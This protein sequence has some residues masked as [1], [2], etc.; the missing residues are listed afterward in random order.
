MSKNLH[1]VPFD[2]FNIFNIKSIYDPTI[3]H[4]TVNGVLTLHKADT[5]NVSIKEYIDEIKK[6]DNTVLQ[7]QSVVNRDNKKIHDEVDALLASKK[8]IYEKYNDV[9][10]AWQLVGDGI[11][12]P[13]THNANFKQ[14]ISSFTPDI[15]G[16]KKYR[17]IKFPKLL[18][19]GGLAWLEVFTKNDPATG[20]LPDGM[21]VKATGKPK[22][23]TAEWKDADENKIK[24]KVA[25]GSTIYLHIYTEALYGQEIEILLR[26][27]KYTIANLTPT[28]SDK[29]GD[30]IQSLKAKSFK[31]FTRK[32]DC[33]QYDSSKPQ[34]I[35]PA[36]SITDQL[37]Q[38]KK[39]TYIQNV[40]KCVFAV[41]IEQ[42]W[43]FQGAGSNYDYKDT[44][45]L[46]SGNELVINPFIFHKNLDKGVTEI[47]AVLKVSR[48]DGKMY[49]G[50]LTGNKPVLVGKNE[51]KNDAPEEKQ[52][53]DF[54]VGVF[55]DGTLNNMFNSEARQK[56]EERTHKVA[57]SQIIVDQN[58]EKKYRYID[59]SSYENDPSNPA[60]LY[61]NY[62]KDVESNPKHK[63]LKV[64]TEGIGTL[65]KPDEKGQLN[66][67]DYKDDDMVGYGLG[68][69]AIYE[70]TGIKR[71]V[72]NAI[73]DMVKKMLPYIDKG[74]T[75]G[76]LTVDVFGFSRGAA[77]A[78]NFVHEI[79]YDAYNVSAGFEKRYCDQHGYAVSE[80]YWKTM[81]L[82]SNGHLGYLLDDANKTFDKLYVRFAGLYDTVP[83][84][85]V[86]QGNDIEDLGLDSINKANYVVH[87]A[88]DNEHRSNFSLVNIS[89]VKKTS[90]ESGEKG[91]IELYFPGVHC[92]V[93]GS[94]VEGHSENKMRIDAMFD[95]FELKKLK[96]ELIQQGWFNEKQL[97]IEEYFKE[98]NDNNYKS[99]VTKLLLNSKRN[100][101]SNQYSFIPLHIMK[102][103]CLKKG[104]AIDS[105]KLLKKYD[106]RENN[107]KGNIDFL[108]QIEK[109][110][111][112][113]A[114][115]GG[116]KFTYHEPKKFVQ[117]NIVYDPKQAT[118][119]L[120]EYNARQL[121]GQKEEDAIADK[122]NIAIKFL[123]NNY[124]HWNSVY[125]QE[126][127]KDVILQPHA[128]NIENNIRKRTIR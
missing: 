95:Y 16:V 41:F 114:F 25:F 124:L 70:N 12:E 8:K 2:P 113:Y 46:D 40:Q 107:I 3:A 93:G 30:P 78:R 80:K 37:M 104:L 34:T 20:K 19:G 72:R 61:Q 103:F 84:H 6:I 127:I 64:Y 128:P 85:G 45:S 75:I 118:K 100:Y 4:A 60:I 58:N 67:K 35:P 44:F 68:T 119:A 62:K 18:E 29:N 101:L 63:I 115:N 57:T 98:I 11:K 22:I 28:P 109:H 77:A 82:P 121:A 24:G 1:I 32:V 13:P 74:K 36:G 69:T 92:D 27:T 99:A 91:G 51:L 10:W 15:N 87:I 65:T 23:I 117:P 120:A 96:L 126:K 83:H 9:N 59:E 106:F 50:E 97:F 17:E 52:K 76:T 38:A 55:I 88:A 102:D 43:S 56:F 66:D 48:T 90:P 33:H 42:A 5:F 112:D 53:I 54:T 116:D 110:L 89:S 86:S 31:H 47:N 123:R 26:D 21:F 81:R 7:K 122:K 73:E 71:K 105:E 111:Q 14:G 94:Y 79:T 125:G 39:Q 49:K 108:K